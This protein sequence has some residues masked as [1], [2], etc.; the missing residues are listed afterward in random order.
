MILNAVFLGM[1]F[2]VFVVAPIFHIIFLISVEKLIAY[3]G[4]KVL[5]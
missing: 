1:I 4:N 5:F 3:Y 2:F